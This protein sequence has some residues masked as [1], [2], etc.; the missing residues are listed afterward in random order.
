MNISI[1]LSEYQSGTKNARVYKTANGEWG[2]LLYDA[3]D[4]YNEFKSFPSE[5]DAEDCAEDW[6]LKDDSV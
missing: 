1:I 6:V 3:S 5:Q 2:V 4:D